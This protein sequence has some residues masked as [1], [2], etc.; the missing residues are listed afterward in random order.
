MSKQL[1]ETHYDEMEFSEEL[2]QNLMYYSPVKLT[3]EDKNVTVKFD[4]YG[5]IHIMSRDDEGRLLKDIPLKENNVMKKN[6]DSDK[7]NDY[8]MQRIQT[9]RR[10][11]T[12]TQICFYFILAVLAGLCS[13]TL[14]M[15][16][17]IGG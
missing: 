2:L 9:L 14:Y 4:S 12:I 7:G 8:L 6:L 3:E 16:R 17:T 15:V 13:F 5:T 10:Q 1:E 11:N